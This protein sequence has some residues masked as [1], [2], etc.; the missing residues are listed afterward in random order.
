MIHN[1]LSGAYGNPWL[2][3]VLILVGIGLMMAT[4]YTGSTV[5]GAGSMPVETK[6]ADYTVVAG[7]DQGKTFNTVGAGGTVVFSL[8]AATVGQRYGFLVGAAQE[9]RIDP[10]GN[11][12][13]ALPETGVQGAAGKYLTANAAG[14]YV[15]LECMI[16]GTWTAIAGTQ[17]SGVWTAEA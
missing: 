14:E 1:I 12:T 15:V 8:P 3:V 9:L 11:E 17:K 10:N 16:A 7:Q 2:I 5:N 13:I 4:T 6:T